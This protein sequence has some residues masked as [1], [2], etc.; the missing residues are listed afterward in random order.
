MSDAAK[1]SADQRAY[2]AAK[3]VKHGDREGFERL[4]LNDMTWEQACEMFGVQ[5]R[6][7]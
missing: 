1:L 7:D 5:G 2:L 6:C 3:A 4:V